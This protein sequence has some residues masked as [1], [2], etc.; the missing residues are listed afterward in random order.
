MEKLKDFQKDLF[1]VSQY[2]VK[3]VG[4]K[5]FQCIQALL[6]QFEATF[7]DGERLTLVGSDGFFRGTANAIFHHFEVVGGSFAFVATVATGSQDPLM[8]GIL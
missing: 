7:V 8:K 2:R 3:N 6:D 5:E 4:E 1:E